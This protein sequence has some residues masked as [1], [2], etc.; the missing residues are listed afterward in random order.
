MK[1]LLVNPPSSFSV[2]RKSKIKSTIPVLPNMALAMLAGVAEKTNHQPYIL[3]MAVLNSPWESLKTKLKEINPTIVGVTATTP[4]FYE[5][6]QIAN[7]S[8]QILGKNVKNILGGP[9]ASALPE[10]CLRNS[11]FDLLVIG[12]G[13]QTF[14]E[15]LDSPNYPDI[16]GIAYLNDGQYMEN[17]PRDLIADLDELP[18]PKLE[19]Y[20]K[21]NYKCPPPISRANP[22]APIEFSRGCVFNCS[23]CNKNIAGRQFRIKSV[24]RILK[25]IERIKELGYKEIHVIDDQFSTNIKKAKEVLKSIIDNN[26]KMPINL[27]TGVR[28]DRIDEE[29]LKLAREAGVYQVG[30]GFESGD[31][32]SLERI[33]KGIKLEQ[34]I[35][36]VEMIKKYNIECVGFFMIGLPGETIEKIRKTIDFAIKLDLDYAKATILVPFPGTRIYQE[37]EERGFIKTYDW[38]KYNFHAAR[39][40]YIHP[41]LDWEIYTAPL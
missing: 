32:E 7:I 30:I 23:F 25:E 4:L 3:D 15:I 10:K 5:A 35:R 18:F 27:R 36:A 38:S 21:A 33:T 6:V 8:K 20:S 2:Y 12:E 31:E 28:V 1:V 34:S 29:F 26:L 40:I 24:V 37:Y 19:L 9:H 22:V 41:T 16:P 14:E 39:E 17:I 13:E 11:Q